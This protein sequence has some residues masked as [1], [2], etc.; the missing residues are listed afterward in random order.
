MTKNNECDSVFSAFN[1]SESAP[2]GNRRLISL[3]TLSVKR[4][5]V[6]DP[7]IA[8]GASQTDVRS[9]RTTQESVDSRMNDFRSTYGDIETMS[10]ETWKKYRKLLPN[11]EFQS[12]VGNAWEDDVFPMGLG[13][14]QRPY[15]PNAEEDEPTDFNTYVLPDALY[16]QAYQ[17]DVHEETA[18]EDTEEDPPPLSFSTL[19]TIQIAFTFLL[20][21]SS[22]NLKRLTRVVVQF[23]LFTSI[24]LGSIIEWSSRTVHTCMVS[25]F[26][27]LSLVN[28]Y[29]IHTSY[30][31]HMRKMCKKRL[32][33]HPLLSER[34]YL[35]LHGLE[36]SSLKKLARGP[37]DNPHLPANFRSVRVNNLASRAKSIK[38]LNKPLQPSGSTFVVKFPPSA[39]SDDRLYIRGEV[40]GS[41]TDILI[42]CGSQATV[43]S[44]HFLRIINSTLGRP[45]TRLVSN[46]K[47]VGVSHDAPINNLGIA[48]L[49]IT[50]TSDLNQKLVLESIPS[51]ICTAPFHI[52]LGMNVLKALEFTCSI[53][54]PLATITFRKIPKFGPM[55]AI[56]QDHEF[57]PL[58]L[59]SVKTIPP[60]FSM[61]L[62][63]H[64]PFSSK[65]AHT[66][67]D[68]KTL[69]V[70]NGTYHVP[71]LK[72]SDTTV[73]R[74]GKC[75]VYAHNETN[76]HITLPYRAPIISVCPLSTFNKIELNKIMPHYKHC[77]ISYMDCCFCEM[78]DT[79]VAL[80]CTFQGHTHFGIQAG[81][82]REKF[83]P[84][85]GITYQSPYF[86]IVPDRKDGFTQFTGPYIDNFKRTHGAKLI[87]NHLTIILAEPLM[88]TG[89]FF[90]FTYALKKVLNVS[91][92]Y[93]D[94]SRLCNRCRLGCLSSLS[95]YPMIRNIR[96]ISIFIPSQFGV[97]D[98]DL[99]GRKFQKIA[100]HPVLSF[101]AEET[102]ATCFL[103]DF[104][105]MTLILHVPH[106]L[107]TIFLR[108]FILFILSELKRVLPYVTIEVLSNL[109]DVHSA[110]EDAIAKGLFLSRLVP[111][112]ES[113]IPLRN[114]QKVDHNPSTEAAVCHYKSCSCMFCASTLGQLRPSQERV[115]FRVLY[116]GMFPSVS[117][118]EVQRNLKDVSRLNQD[119]LAKVNAIQICAAMVNTSENP[120]EESSDPH[121][122]YSKYQSSLISQKASSEK[123]IDEPGLKESRILPERYLA[124]ADTFA[125]PNLFV[126]VDSTIYSAIPI[127][128][129]S[130]VPVGLAAIDDYV[131]FNS[132]PDSRLIGPLRLL[133]FLHRDLLKMDAKSDFG[134]V[135]HFVASLKLKSEYVGRSFHAKG[136]NL[137]SNLVPVLRTIITQYFNLG[138][139][140]QNSSSEISSPV[141]LVLR[142][143]RYTAK[144]NADVG[145]VQPEPD[146]AATPASPENANP[147]GQNPN[148]I[149]NPSQ[150]TSVT[151][152]DVRLVVD[153]RVLNERLKHDYS[154]LTVSNL[155]AQ[156][157]SEYTYGS[158]YNS[159][160]DLSLSYNSIVVEPSSRKY[161]GLKISK[162]AL[163]RSI[164]MLMGVA[165][166]PSIFSILMRKVLSPRTLQCTLTYFDDFFLSS[167]P[168]KPVNS[169]LEPVHNVEKG[170]A[171]PCGQN[172]CN[173]S[174][175]LVSLN[176][177]DAKVP[178]KYFDNSKYKIHSIPPNR[179]DVLHALFDKY[180]PNGFL[181][182]ELI[183]ENY[184]KPP[185]DKGQLWENALNAKLPQYPAKHDSLDIAQVKQHFLNLS[186]LFGDIRFSCTKFSLKKSNFFQSEVKYF[187]HLFDSSTINILPAKKIYLQKFANIKTVKEVQ[188]FLGSILSIGFHISGLAHITRSL[189]NVTFK[190]PSTELT[191]S[192]K[193]IVQ[194]LI[195]KIVDS[196]PL[197]IIPDN[198]S[199]ILIS[200]A[201]ALAAGICIGFEDP[202]KKF[203]VSSYYSVAL[204]ATL[205]H[206]LSTIE[207]ELFGIASYILSSPHILMRQEP[208]IV[209]CDNKSLIKLATANELPFTG[210]L[211]KM[212]NIIRSLPL[213]LRFRWR[214]GDDPRVKI[215]DSL[216]RLLQYKYFMP[217]SLNQLHIEKIL[218]NH[219]IDEKI[220]SIVL[221][222]VI[223]DKDWDIHEIPALIGLYGNNFFA[224]TKAKKNQTRSEYLAQVQSFPFSASCPIR[225]EG[226]SF[227]SPI[228]K[229]E[230]EFLQFHVETLRFNAITNAEKPTLFSIPTSFDSSSSTNIL[231]KVVTHLCPFMRSPMQVRMAKVWRKNYLDIATIKADQLQDLEYGPILRAFMSKNEASI[232]KSLRKKYCLLPSLVLAAR[233]KTDHSFPRVVLPRASATLLL[234]Q[235]HAFSHCSKEQ[236]SQLVGESFFI[237]NLGNLVAM[238][239]ASCIPCVLN[240]QTG[241][242]LYHPGKLERG[243]KPFDI[244]VADHV[245]LFDKYGLTHK[246]YKY[247]IG[248]NCTFSN[249]SVYLPLKSLKL[250]ETISAFEYYFNT[251]GT[252]RKLVT[253]QGSIFTSHGFQKFLNHRNVD[254]KLQSPW[255]PWTHYTERS[256]L[257]FVKTLT[258]LMQALKTR[259]W[260]QLL[261]HANMA[262]R[263]MHR[264]FA[265]FDE[266]SEQII[267]KKISPYELLIGVP[268]HYSL[269]A[270][271]QALYGSQTMPLQILKARKNLHD[272]V[273]LAYKV[274]KALFDQHDLEQQAKVPL[275]EY[276]YVVL[277]Q[278][279]PEKYKNTFQPTIFQVVSVRGRKVTICDVFSNRARTFS[280][281][282]KFVKK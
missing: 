245:Y 95:S 92:L 273:A 82:L 135:R 114:P 108:N 230:D 65:V 279:P 207:K 12:S 153:C 242:K 269:D 224:E 118:R 218:Q 93:G 265:F 270:H 238:I 232:S 73:F 225:L 180:D 79:S 275:A 137:A 129:T 190:P 70:E 17:L 176:H 192:Q 157:I 191:D 179:V 83:P 18:H 43:V 104:Q 4:E 240:K 122:F 237:K 158:K 163:C 202:N 100:G 46:H 24:C 205:T 222:D 177:A 235:V 40:C 112:Y 60:K 94:H 187:G 228:C 226:L 204:P 219:T 15:M 99:N 25:L 102:L 211:Y 132:L 236:L 162:F 53:E 139:W 258:L 221:P 203:H 140:E 110:S 84:M 255:A 50:L 11:D 249:F 56:L 243:C 260:P 261:T 276:D 281:H 126:N 136:Y 220:S 69:L 148:V 138:I 185:I 215:S 259:D 20:N 195:N 165:T 52:L 124:I 246:I 88:A 115:P 42:D 75:K 45:I 208:T 193:E 123:K 9:S 109:K 210:R 89:D 90:D 199:M 120:P 272:A 145:G 212:L 146:S 13:K 154:T 216:S 72:M 62:S 16:Q 31:S 97:P 267:Y 227:P 248:I 35:W 55:K 30:K 256:N 28:L 19:T 244:V 14:E 6:D 134:L 121:D 74:Q 149:T 264:T 168:P 48:S 198:R 106:C 2:N 117:E 151:P 68:G 213:R 160:L 119:S 22:F 101:T 152:N 105:N 253:D 57:T 263:A 262:M 38:L 36:S 133:L 125:R 39:L 49:D 67:L 141:F 37:H 231:G 278:N 27:G 173:K 127:P 91:I 111:G 247:V 174:C 71:G 200:D 156:D 1:Q 131:D 150:M 21:I 266:T 23:F 250:N 54:G 214:P 183:I 164:T 274:E 209:I 66:N 277:K 80:L 3:L 217:G 29:Y 85:G 194:Y 189:Y 166:A 103:Q 178:Q 98:D 128:R 252:P 155:S 10:D 107:G 63:F 257:I 26:L 239:T 171:C 78:K 170:S 64:I 197:K 271:L 144:G 282:I 280:V 44:E 229:S 8:N 159:V 161:L 188:C 182:R 186:H 142:S 116:R 241:P 196:K 251:F 223:A 59:E 147:S 172:Q 184:N 47:L 206:S 87:K 7:A 181:P 233:E 41:P 175:K 86:L 33:K 234:C 143:S 76:D 167:L 81:S 201:S 34:V 254:H 51:Y 58:Q 77:S 61:P 32:R 268:P 130:H 113:G 5:N 169:P 96:S